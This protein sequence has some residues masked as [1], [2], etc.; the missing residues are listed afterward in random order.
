MKVIAVMNQKGGCGKTTTAVSLAYLLATEHKKKVLVI[1][2]DSQGN[3]SQLLGVY[4]P[5]GPGTDGIILDP[6]GKDIENL[7]VSS[8]YM[9]VVPSNEHLQDANIVLA[10]EEAADQVHRIAAAIETVK[11]RYDFVIIDC[12]LLMD[13]TTVNALV[14]A[15][16]WIVPVKPGG[17]EV[18]AMIRMEEQLRAVRTLNPELEQIVL[19]VMVQ[20]TASRREFV[21]W[22]HQQRQIKVFDTMIRRATPAEDY[23]A[24]G[25]PLP[26]Y[27]PKCN[28]AKDYQALALEILAIEKRAES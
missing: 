13:L 18:D 19:P 15:D 22:L 1:D 12:G 23:T 16:L 28:P 27:R 10:V 24:A 9:D 20:N 7:I 6:T 21:E 11:D 8:K 26:Q 4:T 5:D 2:T 14:A 25:M 17:F 3:A